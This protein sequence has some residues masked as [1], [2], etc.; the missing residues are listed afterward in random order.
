MGKGW[1]VGVDGGAPRAKKD[2]VRGK[3]TSGPEEQALRDLAALFDAFP[4]HRA[5][6]FRVRGVTPGRAVLRVPFTPRLTSAYGIHGGVVLALA[7]AA[8]GLA[9]FSAVRPGRRVATV[10]LKLNY[11]A[12]AGHGDLEAEARVVHQ[13]RTTVVSD[14]EVRSAGALKAKA[15]GTYMVLPGRRTPRRAGAGAGA[16]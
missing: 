12:P 10:E 9:A 13:G 14:I 16:D 3:R 6:G 4:L 1:R 7:D 8:G 5:L 2:R 15:L 11:V